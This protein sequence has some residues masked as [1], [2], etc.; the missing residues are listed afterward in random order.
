M[1]LDVTTKPGDNVQDLMFPVQQDTVAHRL[2]TCS[3]YVQVGYIYEKFEDT[4][5]TMGNH[6]RTDNAIAKGRGGKSGCSFSEL[7]FNKQVVYTNVYV[8]ISICE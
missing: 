8:R 4:K 5:G 7:D 1:T 6:R 3:V 2:F